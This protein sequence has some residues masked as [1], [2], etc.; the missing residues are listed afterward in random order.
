[1]TLKNGEKFL[2]TE[3]RTYICCVME[4]SMSKVMENSISKG[5]Y[6]V[7]ETVPVPNAE[8]VSDDGVVD[9]SSLTVAEKEKYLNIAKSLNEKDLTS[10]SN[11]GSEL[12]K[13]MSDYSNEF[14][15]QQMKSTTS[16]ETARLISDLLAELNNVDIDDLESPSFITRVA[17]KIPLVRSLVTSVEQIKT[18]YNTIQKNI[19]GIVGKL[20]ATRQIAIRDN[21]L[22]QQQFENNCDYVDQ[23]EE[24][25]IAGQVKSNELKN[26]IQGME[27]GTIP[28]KDFELSDLKAFKE[29]LDKR[30][31]DLALI[32]YAFKQSLTQ[33]RIIQ[34][35]N[36]MDANN[37]ESQIA[38][39]I[40]LWKNQLSLA[41]AL[42][43]QKQSIEVKDKVTNVTNEILRKNSEMM[44]TQAIEV[45]RQNQRSVIDIETLRETTSNLLATVEG[46]RK[47]QIEGAQK[48]LE[49]ENE[50]AKLEKQMTQTV[51]AIAEGTQH[52]V[53]KELK[54]ISEH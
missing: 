27:N 6:E 19:D 45:A 40:P 11:Y 37:T 4:N 25:I 13:V 31:S 26:T 44:K 24:L 47:A 42:Y 21:N 16:I 3:K 9:T 2:F 23:L 12:Q 39:T 49:A 32:R 22:L 36:I 41:V 54:A 46:V 14:L 50:I 18:K 35:T 15:T 28:C 43:N 30:L 52:V 33:I 34:H 51:M 20:E 7:L 48:R 17:R 38:M 5:T 29:A 53:A 1:M 10:V 8:K